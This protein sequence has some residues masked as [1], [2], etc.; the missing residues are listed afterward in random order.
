MTKGLPVDRVSQRPGSV[1]ESVGADEVVPFEVRLALEAP[2]DGARIEA[3]QAVLA[4]VLIPSLARQF[5]VRVKGLDE[6]I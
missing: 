1:E 4:A 5:P 3:S 2:A 6:A